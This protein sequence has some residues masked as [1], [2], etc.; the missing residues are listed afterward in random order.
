MDEELNF[1]QDDEIS[2]GMDDPIE[3]QN[4]S[5]VEES[6]R[7]NETFNAEDLSREKGFRAEYVPQE[8]MSW[9]NPIKYLPSGMYSTK[10]EFEKN[11]DDIL[12]N[13][14]TPIAI[15]RDVMGG[16]AANAPKNLAA[17]AVAFKDWLLGQETG[18]AQAIA[19]AYPTY[20]APENREG[21]M[22]DISTTGGELLFGGGAVAG[23]WSKAFKNPEVVANG[24]SKLV[25][26]LTK[27]LSTGGKVAAIEAGGVASSGL[28]TDA[29]LADYLGKDTETKT[30]SQDLIERRGRALAEALAAV[31]VGEMGMRGIAAGGKILDEMF[32]EPVKTFFSKNVMDRYL[33]EKTVRLIADIKPTDSPEEVIT[34]IKEVRDAAL[35]HGQSKKI[36]TGESGV[37]KEVVSDRDTMSAI[38]IGMNDPLVTAKARG[39]RRGLQSTGEAPTL[40]AKMSQPVRETEELFSDM[41]IGAGGDK[42]LQSTTESI[43]TGLQ[44]PARELMDQISTTRQQLYENKEGIKKLMTEDKSLGQVVDNLSDELRL[45]TGKSVSEMTADELS[46]TIQEASSSMTKRKNEL[47]DAIPESAQVRKAFLDENRILVDDIL[48][49][50]LKSRINDAGR[51]FK[52][53][54]QIVNFDEYNR[55]IDTLKAG[56]KFDEAERLIN[57]KRAVTDDELE[58]L[59]VKGSSGTKEALDEAKRYYLKEYAPYWRNN[60]TLSNIQKKSRDFKFA[61][62]MRAVETRDE[63]LKQLDNPDTEYINRIGEFFKSPEGKGQ[64]GKLIDYTKAKVA[65]AAQDMIY[66]SKDGKLSA[67]DIKSLGSLVQKYNKVINAVDPKETEQLASFFS[68]IKKFDVSEGELN[69]LLKDQT[70]QLKTLRTEL[71]NSPFFGDKLTPRTN[72][73]HIYD[74]VFDDPDVAQ[75][76]PSLIEKSGGDRKGLEVAFADKLKK[77][78]FRDVEGQAGQLAMKPINNDDFERLMKAGEVLFGKESKL[79][80]ATRMLKDDLNRQL[81]TGKG[82]SPMDVTHFSKSMR[83]VIDTAV[84]QTVGVLNTIGARAR[85]LG[86]KV[87]T[88]YDPKE[89]SMYILDKIYSDPEEFA[90]ILDKVIAHKGSKISKMTDTDR[91][92]IKKFFVGSTLYGPGDQSGIDAQT[93]EVFGSKDTEE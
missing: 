78:F 88:K 52:K 75:K 4:L 87:V 93:N 89:Y 90:R 91:N 33:G 20:K 76:L 13:P 80:D 34:K 79:L 65:E 17:T 70:D 10:E 23:L 37:A 28:E 46:N 9:Y 39:A 81:A 68:Q 32:A 8:H 3:G 12:D 67:D 71:Q 14:S 11:R 43:Q 84:T 45:P 19:E 1:G 31:K 60:P 82:F 38:E 26:I 15:T 6:V 48:P 30:F 72:T 47:Y 35:E 66:K 62:D 44:K 69:T 86:S 21:F 24:A 51:S 41:R 25:N 16:Y 74:K 92:L 2:F 29:F 59:V 63:L 27:T 42:A 61:D 77:T 73:T 83:G 50:T 36:I 7:K 5:P 18:Q 54:H 58:H 55:Y 53:L 56:G 22:S 49:D 57:F 85:S 64:A 40:E